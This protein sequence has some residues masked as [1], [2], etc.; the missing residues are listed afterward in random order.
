LIWTIHLPLELSGL[1]T[2]TN[3]FRQKLLTEIL[4]ETFGHDL[5][6]LSMAGVSS[7]TLTYFGQERNG[8]VTVLLILGRSLKEITLPLKPF[9]NT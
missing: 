7:E 5:M 9:S 3:L 4:I 1:S 2:K 6:I 8:G